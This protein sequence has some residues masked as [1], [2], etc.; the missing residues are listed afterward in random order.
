MLLLEEQ[1]KRLQTLYGD[2]D[3]LSQK[4]LEEDL[5]RRRQALENRKKKQNQRVIIS[6][7]WRSDTANR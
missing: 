7:L 2:S 6:L 1:L 4:F 5:K 3:E